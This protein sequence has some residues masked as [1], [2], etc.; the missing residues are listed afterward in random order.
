[1]GR[2]SKDVKSGWRGNPSQR[3]EMSKA[4]W[5]EHSSHSLLSGTVV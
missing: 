1:M 5:Q 3:L 4:P 2:D